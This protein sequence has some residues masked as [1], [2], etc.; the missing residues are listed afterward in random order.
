MLWMC[1][2]VL[3]MV[4][5]GCVDEGVLWMRCVMDVLI[6]DVLMKVCL[7]LYWD[8]LMKVYCGCFIKDSVLWV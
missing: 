8:V 4:Y 7:G 1:W 3:M 6:M 5:C 2:D